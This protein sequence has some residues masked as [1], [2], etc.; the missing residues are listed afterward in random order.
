MKEHGKSQ[1]MFVSMVLRDSDRRGGKQ[2]SAGEGAG[3]GA[4]APDR[5]ETFAIIA[6]S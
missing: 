5:Q 2:D 1:L 4:S 6:A 3:K